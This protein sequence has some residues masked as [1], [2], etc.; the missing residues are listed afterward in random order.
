MM[1]F[2]FVI[3]VLAIFYYRIRIKN[4]AHALKP[5]GVDIG[6]EG[7]EYFDTIYPSYCE[8]IGKH[9]N[10]FNRD[11]RKSFDYENVGPG[12]VRNLFSIRD[13]VLY[14]ISEI[15]L[16]LPNDLVLEKKIVRIYE[17]ADRKMM[18]FITDVKSRFHINITPGQTSAAFA[19]RNYRARDDVVI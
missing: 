9:L 2:L 14:N 13:D 3:L 17:A 1:L 6:I 16:R 15:R 4:F 8:N 18:E 5:K 10:N 19:A 12:L 11:Y 7:M